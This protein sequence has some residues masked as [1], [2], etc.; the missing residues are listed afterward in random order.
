MSIVGNVMEYGQSTTKA[1]S[2]FR[3]NQA[4]P[5]ELF[6]EDNVAHDR[7]GQDVPQVG[8]DRLELVK[9]VTK[10]PV[11]PEGLKA[12]PASEIKTY[13]AKN[14]GAR[15]WN[16]DA[17]DERIVNEALAGTGRIID[18]ETEVGGYPVTPETRAKFNADEWDLAT[19]Q[20][21]RP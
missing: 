8:G 4:G 13:V 10:R 3:F 11:W 16:R 2:L 20:R 5:L 17:I 7:S 9:R 6:M 1:L 19:M 14:A 12:L 21:R 15:P 18:S